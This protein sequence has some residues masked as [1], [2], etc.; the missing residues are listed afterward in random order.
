MDTEAALPRVWEIMSRDVVA[1]SSRTPRAEAERTLRQRKLVSAPV[2]N[3]HM[4]V[5]GTLGPRELTRRRGRIVQEFMAA[6]AQTLDEERPLSEAADLLL[7]RR[8]STLPV[9]NH[10]KL[11]GRLSRTAL[12]SYFCHHLWVCGRCGAAQR[13]ITPP[14]TC[15][16]CGG[17][18]GGFHLED[19]WPGL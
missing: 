9:V 15:P 10:G 11:V 13:G 3:E 8:L 7:N 1:I 17:P 16:D 6:P 14:S 18:A 5:V 19:S 12:V 2:V 4:E